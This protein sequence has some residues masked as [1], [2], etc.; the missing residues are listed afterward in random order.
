M[1]DQSL[2]NIP[3]VHTFKAGANFNVRGGG[4]GEEQ[5]VIV[6]EDDLDGDGIADQEEEEA[7]ADEEAINGGDA[8]AAAEAL[9]RK[10]ARQEANE[11]KDLDEKIAS[12]KIL[13]IIRDTVV[14][15]GTTIR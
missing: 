11:S 3:N 8:V 1:I 6:N 15:E 10:K 2:S 9:K 12:D 7:E 5:E 4:E 14:Q 13:N